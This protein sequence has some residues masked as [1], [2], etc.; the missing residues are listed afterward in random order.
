M[1]TSIRARVAPDSVS[2][3]SVNFQSSTPQRKI[4]NKAF[5]R[6]YLKNEPETADN[7]ENAHNDES[8]VFN[9][10]KFIQHP[11]FV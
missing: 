2:S 1:C 11:R 4:L 10:N 9:V 6:I 7:I 5:F 3:F 8:R